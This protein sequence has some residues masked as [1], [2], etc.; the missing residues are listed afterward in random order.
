MRAS[1]KRLFLFAS[2][3]SLLVFSPLSGAEGEAAEMPADTVTDDY[4][5][6][7]ANTCLG[8]HADQVTAAIFSTKHAQRADDRTPFGDGNTQCEACHGPGGEHIKRLKRGMAAKDRPSMPYWGSASTASTAEHN[9][10]C[11]NCHQQQVGLHWAGSVHDVEDTNCADCHKLH[12]THQAVL[13]PE[14]QAAVC[15]TCHLE[16][17]AN[18]QKPYAHPIRL[19]RMACT[20]CHNPHGSAAEYAL[21]KNTLNDTCY[22][23]HQEKRGPLLWEHAPVAEDCSNCHEPHGTIHA[24]MLKRTAPLLCQS[25]HSQ[26]GHP[27]IP[28]TASG[29]AGNPNPSQYLLGGS[30]MNCHS[31]VHGSN[32]PSG[33]NLMR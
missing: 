33:A 9:Q 7:G 21:V 5:L 23:C 11:M 4:S 6:Q 24:G 28:Y 32:H 26:A 29:L 19:G 12:A 27:S 18:A 14:T 1:H 30:C 25:C 3:L 10:Q 16:Q 8:C 22:G 20:D 13:R 2:V 17:K 31:Q 15:Y